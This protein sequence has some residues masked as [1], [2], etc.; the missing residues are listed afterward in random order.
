M[1]ET[2]QNILTIAAIGAALLLGVFILRGVV[3]WVWKIVRVGLVL[4]V[5]VLIAGYFFGFIN[6]DLPMIGNW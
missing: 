5:I 2:I 4:L 6:L 1:N 3:K